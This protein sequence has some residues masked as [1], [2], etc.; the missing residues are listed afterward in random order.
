[1]RAAFRQTARRRAARTAVHGI[2]VDEVKEHA[3]VNGT[4]LHGTE[5]GL[6]TLP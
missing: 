1:M 6:R 5:P 2:R 3:W 4:D